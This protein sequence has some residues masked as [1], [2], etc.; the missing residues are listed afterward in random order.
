M[1]QSDKEFARFAA[2]AL[3][4]LSELEFQLGICK[5][6]GYLSGSAAEAIAGEIV[7]VRRQISRLRSTLS[8]ETDRSAAEH[9]K[10]GSRE[11]G[12]GGR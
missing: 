12:A 7:S 1:R 5:R 6:L 2:I 8:V 9:W 3:G 11:L 4:S 10:A